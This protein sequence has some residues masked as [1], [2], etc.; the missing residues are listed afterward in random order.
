MR[1]TSATSDANKKIHLPDI[2]T[3]TPYRRCTSASSVESSSTRMLTCRL[4]F[5]HIQAT[6][7]TTARSVTTLQV[8][9]VTTRPTCFNI[10]ERNLTNVKSAASRLHKRAT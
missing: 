1:A 9:Q 5:H 4:I 7:S 8:R 6:T 3:P 2:S 10:L